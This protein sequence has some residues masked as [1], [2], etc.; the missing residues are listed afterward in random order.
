MTY[1]LVIKNGTLVT[2]SETF[3][4][5]G[6]YTDPSGDPIWEYVDG[7]SFAVL[8][9]H[10]FEPDPKL[11]VEVATIEGVPV[12]NLDLHLSELSHP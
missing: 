1:D 6:L 3:N 9:V 7:P 4:R 10:P 5:I 12:F 8:T 2:A 11:S